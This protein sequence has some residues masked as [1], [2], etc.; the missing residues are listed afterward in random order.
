[1]YHILS[2]FN[3]LLMNNAI[4]LHIFTYQYSDVFDLENHELR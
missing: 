1:M 3:T 4:N 2:K